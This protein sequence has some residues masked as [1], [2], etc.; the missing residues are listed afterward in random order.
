M[1]SRAAMELRSTNCS[2]GQ[3][4]V[5]GARDAGEEDRES[6]LWLQ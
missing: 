6:D 4:L 5:L 1:Y 3:E 2:H